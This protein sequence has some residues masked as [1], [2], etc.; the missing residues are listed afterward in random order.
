MSTLDESKPSTPDLSS[1][2]VD[3]SRTSTPDVL[4]S[5]TVD[6]SRTSTPDVFSLSA[7]E[8]IELPT[9]N[10]SEVSILIFSETMF[11]KNL[12]NEIVLTP[13]SDN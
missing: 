10:Q 4:S 12:R 2:T 7:V 11:E 13:H 8:E 5:S 6:G 1:S 3:G 9:L